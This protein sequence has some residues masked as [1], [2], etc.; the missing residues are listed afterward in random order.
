MT[1]SLLP[2]WLAARLP[3]TLQGAEEA[4]AAAE[5]AASLSAAADVSMATENC[6]LPGRAFRP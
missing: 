3:G 4:V 6:T 5:A 2:D 1:Y